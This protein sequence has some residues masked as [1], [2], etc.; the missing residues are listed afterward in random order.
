MMG[1]S[2]FVVSESISTTVVSCHGEKCEILS[3]QNCSGFKKENIFCL[4]EGVWWGV[5]DLF[6]AVTWCARTRACCVRVDVVF[7]LS[8]SLSLIIIIDWH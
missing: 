7:T 8:L 1:N 2:S 5:G 4:E 3:E 6:E